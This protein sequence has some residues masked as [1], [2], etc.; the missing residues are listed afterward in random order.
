ML[1]SSAQR[2]A[3]VLREAQLYRRQGYKVIPIVGLGGSG[4]S[5]FGNLYCGYSGR[6][7]FHVEHG[8]GEGTL[9][10]TG[11][12]NHETRIFWL[13]TRGFSP[14]FEYREWMGM[15]ET[16]G[17]IHG[18][19]L[20]GYPQQRVYFGGELESFVSYV[21]AEGFPCLKVFRE[22]LASVVESFASPHLYEGFLPFH[23]DTRNAQIEA[24]IA[25]ICTR[26]ETFRLIDVRSLTSRVIA[27]REALGASEATNA[28]LR[29]DNERLQTAL[30]ETEALLKRARASTSLLNAKFTYLEEECGRYLRKTLRRRSHIPERHRH[31]V[32]QYKRRGLNHLAS[33]ILLL[34]GQFGAMWFN[35]KNIK[36]S[37]EERD[38][39]FALERV[40][41]YIRADMEGLPLVALSPAAVDGTP[42]V[43][44]HVTIGAAAPAPE[45]SQPPPAA[46]AVHSGIVLVTNGSSLSTSPSPSS[47]TDYSGS[48]GSW[49]TPEGGSLVLGPT[50]TTTATAATATDG[51]LAA[52]TASVSTQ[53]TES[54]SE[55]PVEPM[56]QGPSEVLAIQGP[57][58]TPDDVGHDSPGTRTMDE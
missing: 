55:F 29:A 18:L 4:K 17:D 16:L 25:A 57:T 31:D 32:H 22:D 46:M 51:T 34:S 33:V 14:R 40:I 27:L 15:L 39:A 45:S 44:H 20:I 10:T 53:L 36:T 47:S 56:I 13:D 35:E 48:I 1:Q 58:E 28:E 19:V 2:E 52:A 5:T 37:R 9:E 43:H 26:S 38:N 49:S 6:A 12:A 30:Q 50:E 41:E 11:Y 8:Q 21:A 54:S 23:R 24:F 7:P 42:P 3:N